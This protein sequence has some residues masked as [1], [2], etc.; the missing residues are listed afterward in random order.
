MRERS[1][2]TAP[3]RA[4]H[5]VAGS[6][7]EQPTSQASDAPPRSAWK[8]A[9]TANRARTNP[10]RR[11][12]DAGIAESFPL[13]AAPIHGSPTLVDARSY[14]GHAACR[15]RPGLARR[16]SV[17]DRQ[18]DEQ[19]HREKQPPRR[20][21]ARPQRDEGDPHAASPVAET[22]I[23]QLPVAPSQNVREPVANA[24]GARYIPAVRS[25]S[26]PDSNSSRRML[27]PLFWELRYA[28]A[29]FVLP[30]FHAVTGRI[31]RSGDSRSIPLFRCDPDH[32]SGFG[33]GLEFFDGAR[34][35]RTCE[36]TWFESPATWTSAA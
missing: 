15:Q 21:P 27:P 29:R 35:I 3:W 10:N 6:G 2:S 14:V 34:T 8:E 36:R 13:V 28:R 18:R 33:P 5:Q 31:G 19:N 11:R 23:A 1:S 17:R 24:P 20:D 4:H 16:R 22:R 9:R 26:T 32:S 30:R 12:R 25:S 7:R